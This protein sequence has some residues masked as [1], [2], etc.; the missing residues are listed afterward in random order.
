MPL[1]AAAI[2]VGMVIVYL[3]IIGNQGNSPAWWFVALM[4][5]ASAL[6]AYGS[7][8]NRDHRLP[9]L[10]LSAF[11]FVGLGFLSIFTIGLPIMLAAVLAGVGAALA[12]GDA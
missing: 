9:A 2:G 5:I 10:A 1:L 6:A 11:L 12:T 3:E 7:L 4:L 8:G